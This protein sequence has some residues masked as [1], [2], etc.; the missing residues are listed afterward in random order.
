MI[1]KNIFQTWCTRDLHP[2]IQNKIDSIKAL[3]PTYIQ[4]YKRVRYTHKHKHN[5]NS[6][7]NPGLQINLERSAS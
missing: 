5:K 4:E 7:D 2:T 6:T 3:N 1:E